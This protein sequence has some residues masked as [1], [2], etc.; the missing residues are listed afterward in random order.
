VFVSVYCAVYNA[1]WPGS[2]A[3]AM[4]SATVPAITWEFE[5]ELVLSPG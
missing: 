2:L 1:G 3:G 5:P 4:L